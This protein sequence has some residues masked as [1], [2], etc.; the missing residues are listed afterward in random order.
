MPKP[1]P[2]G[3]AALRRVL[4]SFDATCVVVGA[5][6]GVG[7]FFV[8]S[9][10]AASAGSAE[11][12]L[13]AW[14]AG[15]LIALAGALTFAELGVSFPEAG[16]QYV[17]LRAAY[18]PLPAY[19]FAFCNATAIQA[20]AIAIIALICAEN[21]AIAAG[22]PSL[23]PAYTTALAAGLIVALAVANCLGVRWGAGVQNLT[24]LARLA[25]LV[26]IIVLAVALAPDAP[27]ETAERQKVP[28][29]GPLPLMLF[30]AVVPT[31]FAYGGWQHALWI[32]GEVRNPS[33]NLPI[34]IVGGVIIVVAVYLAANWAYLALL[35]FQR[36]V[37][38]GALAADAV[39]SVWNAAGRRLVAGA[40]AIS[41][42]GVLNAQLLSGP[43]LLYR[44]AGDGRFFGVFARVSRRF[45]TPAAAI[46]LLACMGL[47]LLLT[48]GRQQIDQ[49]LTG[50]V[51]VDGVFFGLT[52]LAVFVLRARHRMRT[53]TRVFA[54]PFAPAVFVLGEAAIMAGAYYE[55]GKRGAI[56]TGVAW[57]LAG[58]TLYLLRFRKAGRCGAYT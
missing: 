15:G 17:V 51:F 46:C 29:A 21:A 39:G 32:A 56:L 31:F 48:T 36:V 3:S 45:A 53:G 1:G 41:A 2:E 54:Y 55:P 5:I 50:V 37:A 27:P 8:P 16:G 33:R 9:H 49:L 4:G 18:G 34:A 43:R 14:A 25:T 12:A 11:L 7:I 24:V 10:V 13:L 35:G 42:L 23:A 38:S 52:G 22:V 57:I 47:V 28:P 6:V 58:L 30:A 19:L 44:M 40:V 26:A 20:G